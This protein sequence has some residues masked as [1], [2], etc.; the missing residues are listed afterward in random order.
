MTDGLLNTARTLPNITGSFNV[1]PAAATNLTRVVIVPKIATNGPVTFRVRTSISPP[2]AL[3]TNWK[4]GDFVT[5]QWNDS[6]PVDVYIPTDF[7]AAVR[8][9]QVDVAASPGLLGLYEV[10]GFNDA[11]ATLP[12]AIS[13][14]S[15][16]LRPGLT[17]AIVPTPS[18]ASLSNCISSAPTIASLSAGTV[19]A[20]ARGDATI[21]CGG[22]S[23]Q[24]A[25]RNPRVLAV[26][27]EGGA[28]RIGVPT[29]FT[30]TGRDLE[31]PLRF[32]VQGC[33]G[34]DVETVPPPRPPYLFQSGDPSTLRRFVCVPE[35]QPGTRF[36]SVRVG[37]KPELEVARAF[38]GTPID[39]LGC[40]QSFAGCA[41]EVLAHLPGAPASAS[42]RA[43]VIESLRAQYANAVSGEIPWESMSMDTAHAIGRALRQSGVDTTEPEFVR[44]M[45]FRDLEALNLKMRRDVEATGA[46]L[47]AW[48]WADTIPGS[49]SGFWSAWASSATRLSKKEYLVLGGSI[50][51]NMTL[52]IVEATGVGTAA[53]GVI[54][55]KAAAAGTWSK[56][57]RRTTVPNRVKKIGTVLEKMAHVAEVGDAATAFGALT[58]TEQAD[59]KEIIQ[60]FKPLAGEAA[61]QYS[62]IEAWVDA[63][64]LAGSFGEL[65]RA[66]LIGVGID[67]LFKAPSIL[68][69]NGVSKAAFQNLLLSMGEAGVDNTPIVGRIKAVYETSDKVW[70]GAYD[71]VFGTAN[72]VIEAS[73]ALALVLQN[74]YYRLRLAWI[75]GDHDATAG[76]ALMLQQKF[77][78]STL[79]PTTGFGVAPSTIER[80]VAIAHGWNSDAAGWVRPLLNAFCA[81]R[82]LP[83]TE[84]TTDL[85][86]SR[87]HAYC[88]GGGWLI[89]GLNWREEARLLGSQQ[90]SWRTPEPALAN[91][92]AH[93]EKLAKELVDVGV[94]PRLLHAV[95]HS[96]GSGFVHALTARMRTSVAGLTTHNTYLD[97]YCPN[98]NACFYGQYA[99]WSEQYVDSRP[100]IDHGIFGSTNVDLP[101]YNFDVTALD[102]RQL[103]DPAGDKSHAWPYVL[104]AT[105]AGAVVENPSP[106]VSTAIGPVLSAV[107]SGQT[108]ANTWLSSI[109]TQLKSPARCGV[110]SFT[111]PGYGAGCTDPKVL[112][113]EG[114]TPS[115][116]GAGMT[117]P[118][119]PSVT[120]NICA[121]TSTGAPST[122]FSLNLNCPNAANAVGLGSGAKSPSVVSAIPQATLRYTVSLDFSANELTARAT[123]TGASADAVLSLFVNDQLVWV[124]PAVNGNVAETLEPIPIRRMPAGTH[125]VQWVL[126]G[127]SGSI[128]VTDL[129]FRLRSSAPVHAQIGACG[130]ANSSTPSLKTP[131]KSSLCEAGSPTSVQITGDAY[132]WTCK[133]TGVAAAA[134]VNCRAAI[135]PCD[136]DVDGNGSVDPNVDGML[137]LRF[138]S[139][140]RGASL[141][142]GLTIPG[143]RSS[144]EAIEAFIG[145]AHQ[146]EIFGRSGGGPTAV[147][148]GLTH[149]RI[150]R[151]FSDTSLLTGIGVPAGAGLTTPAD[152]RSNVLAGCR[153]P[154]P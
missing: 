82:G 29:V 30:V 34:I 35:G 109:P 123:F 119:S 83:V 146:Y 108:N 48:T 71:R 104:Y 80:V 64:G 53:R 143:P 6:E 69:E 97:A 90:D 16:V 67:I 144:A 27:A 110:N 134:T 21:T 57:A 54:R 70:D 116:S 75:F 107:W 41:V 10:M 124:A 3:I 94:Q 51:S 14:A 148:D 96:A 62:P 1:A 60:L 12:T 129:Q 98:E 99:S 7:G 39:A 20:V 131:P 19:T 68:S 79:M 61:L 140:F 133:G 17:T 18:T 120:R 145:S 23:V 4:T 154:T 125:Y 103:A 95:G 46:S 88:A 74:D 45:R 26:S 112:S 138:L 28:A 78:S 117:S 40:D 65:E 9:V 122:G 72:D 153:A 15:T 136:R 105:S 73:G 11:V 150:M 102:S 132:R 66:A 137:L 115:R 89:V 22:A 63:G 50:A 92:R 147:H 126:S 87:I 86:F 42:A 100:T 127:T 91:A 24:I 152:V 33:A 2:G 37:G 151:G 8:T 101:G 113:V 49:G 32:S 76:Q 13:L 43:A 52:A 81:R 128:D 121:G 36:V 139:G 31:G 55:A 118:T 44:Q 135:A 25:V 58:A 5:R 141:V 59:W 38:I 142:S 56:W 93:G 77:R 130:A 111:S 47:Q 106:Q 84:A 85:S 149:L 114:L